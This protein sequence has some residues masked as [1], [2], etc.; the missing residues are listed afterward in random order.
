MGANAPSV[1][2]T[3]SADVD[4]ADR[5]DDDEDDE[6][7]EVVEENGVFGSTGNG[8]RKAAAP[9]PPPPLVTTAGEEEDDEEEEEEE[10]D[11]VDSAEAPVVAPLLKSRGRGVTSALPSPRPPSMAH[12]A[13]RASWIPLVPA[14]ALHWSACA[15]AAPTPA[16]LAPAAW[17]A[18]NESSVRSAAAAAGDH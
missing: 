3:R 15:A 14:L 5:A 4:T 7:D 9:P 1:G 13:A 12:Q 11:E 10:E 18:R 6:E 17:R 2:D 8:E 16:A